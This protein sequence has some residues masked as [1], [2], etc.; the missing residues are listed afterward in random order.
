VNSNLPAPI[1]SDDQRL[2][3]PKVKVVFG[4]TLAPDIESPAD[5]DKWLDQLQ[6]TFGIED[7]TYAASLLQKLVTS[8]ITVKEGCELTASGL[9]AAVRDMQPK[10]TVQAMIATQLVALNHQ[11]M[12]LLEKATRAMSPDLERSYLNQAMKV[13]KNFVM[14][15]DALRK[16]QRNGHQK[17][18]VER[19]NVSS[20]G[21]AIVG[22]V[23]GGA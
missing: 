15:A 7:S 11:A 8:S 1:S 12:K 22:S 14:L 17:I 2:P 16:Q 10:G 13:I 19:V 3:A 6:D 18:V 20:G 9:L 5:H 4:D 21:Q 23:E